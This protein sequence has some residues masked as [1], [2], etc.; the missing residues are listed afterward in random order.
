MTIQILDTTPLQQF[1]VL[2]KKTKPMRAI[3]MS[4]VFADP[5]FATM[6]LVNTIEGAE[7]VDSDAL[8]CIGEAG[9]VWQQKYSKMQSKYDLMEMGSSGWI[10][11]T[12]KSEN[13]QR[14]IQLTKEVLEPQLA[15][16]NQPVYIQGGYGATIDGIE[17]LQQVTIGSWLVQRLPYNGDQWIVQDNLFQ[18]TYALI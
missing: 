5:I 6:F 10:I 18:N 11:A 8:L 2:A 1:M 12:P 14:V 3:H 13:E 7:P 9:D 15:N 4:R 16:L 17:N